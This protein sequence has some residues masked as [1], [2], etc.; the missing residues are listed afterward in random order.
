MRA[1]HLL[2]EKGRDGVQCLF[3]G[4]FAVKRLRQA[5][6]KSDEEIRNFLHDSDLWPHIKE[7]QL[8]VYI[9]RKRT[10]LEKLLNKSA[11]IERL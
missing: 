8:V 5:G 7:G 4:R 2:S 9:V 1:R 3:L 6:V 11:K 10:F